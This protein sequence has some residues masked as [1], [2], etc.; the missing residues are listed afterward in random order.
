MDNVTITEN[1]ARDHG[2]GIYAT[3]GGLDIKGDSEIT[4][5][6]AGDTGG[7]HLDK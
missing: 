3:N 4:L 1:F 6:S 5:N 7:G 2:G